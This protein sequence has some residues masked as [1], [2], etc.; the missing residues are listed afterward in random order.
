MIPGSGLIGWQVLQTTMSKQR[1]AFNASAYLARDTEYF[2][3]KI[4]GVTSGD[5]LVNDRRL[6]S[7]ALAAFGLSDQI[8][9]AYLIKRVLNE[10]A[11]NDDALAN[12]LKDGRYVALA[13]AF[14][15]E[16]T[17][18]FPF[19]E[20]GFAGDIL[21]SYDKRIR[22]DLAD[23]LEEPEYA[24]NPIAAET[25]EATV[26]DGLETTKTYFR[27][28]IGSVTSV[29][30]LMKDNDLLKVALTAFGVEERTNSK[31][32][33][34]RVFEEGATNPGALANVLGDKGLIAMTKAF[35][36]DTEPTTAIRTEE[37]ADKIIDNYQWQA[38]EDAVNEVNPTIGTALSFQRGAP[39]LAGLSGSEN[40]KWFNV[41]GDSTMRE[42]FQTALGL[43]SSF[44]QIDIDKQVE[45][46][47]EKAASRFGITQFKDL[48]DEAIRN[49]VIYSYLLQSDVAANAG[50]GSQQIALT[51]LSS[52]Q[53]QRT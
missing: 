33:L 31:T 34:K 21:A 18:N 14:S 35:G 45:M 40:T 11:E 8:D 10:G 4:G 27:E 49:K 43:P 47:K 36:F 52:I 3:E 13:R 16:E 20:E 39:A 41:L 17:T 48:E 32:L 9:S 42:V 25:L 53:N 29:D 30:D 6:L 46:M 51:L 7:V 23:L 5:D 44:S 19:Q 37:F 50:F 28:T 38:F 24:N 2:K 22:S 12:K 15:F 26:L 1:T